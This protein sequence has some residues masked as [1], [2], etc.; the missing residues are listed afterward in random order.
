MN[1]SCE[2]CS[3]RVPCCP[4]RASRSRNS[5][6]SSRV[7]SRLFRRIRRSRRGANR[8]A[9]R[10]SANGLAHR[11]PLKGQRGP[12]NTGQL[13]ERLCFSSRVTLADKVLVVNKLNPRSPENGVGVKFG[14]DRRPRKHS[15]RMD[16]NERGWESEN[17][18][19]AKA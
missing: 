11:P 16:A 18:S 2:T 7:A 4:N 12:S 14:D 6:S 3:T 10:S 17:A 9:A 8:L 19:A 13:L 15:G 5:I 1:Y